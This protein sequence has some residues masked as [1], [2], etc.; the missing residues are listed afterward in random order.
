MIAR[1]IQWNCK[2]DGI[3]KKAYAYLVFQNNVFG[4]DPKFVDEKAGNFQL[5][6]DSP[7]FKVGFQRIPIEKIGLYQS[8][9]RAQWPIKE[10]AGS[11]NKSALQT[12]Q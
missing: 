8:P 4:P 3:E 10:A 12:N 5:R 6:E 11:A 2:G 1:N 7:A 9:L